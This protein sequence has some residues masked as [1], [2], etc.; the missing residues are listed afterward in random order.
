MQPAHKAA[1]GA[2]AVAGAVAATTA[3]V[4][5]VATAAA[6]TA[7]T[8]I[9]SSAVA[10]SVASSAV[11]SSAHSVLFSHIAA[12][13]RA[14]WGHITNKAASSAKEKVTDQLDSK[15]ASTV[16]ISIDKGETA[17][18]GDSAG[19][20]AAL[21]V[22]GDSAG[23]PARHTTIPGQVCSTSFLQLPVH[24]CDIPAHDGVPA[25][26]RVLMNADNPAAP[27]K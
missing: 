8:S 14:L 3:A 12:G 26:K 6:A 2:V 18:V 11:A 7:T 23:A 10:S 24:I 15:I 1:L 21:A 5:T 19:S 13:A 27:E 4:S 25:T 9:A 20:S 22:S 16:G 17:V